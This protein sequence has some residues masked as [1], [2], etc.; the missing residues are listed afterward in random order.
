MGVDV[1]VGAAIILLGM[2]GVS[3]SHPPSS[4]VRTTRRKI[5][6]PVKSAPT[7]IPRWRSNADLAARPSERS[8][9][10]RE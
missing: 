7:W 9:F 6:E 8:D 1:R 3:G 10:T 5:D 4:I 2:A